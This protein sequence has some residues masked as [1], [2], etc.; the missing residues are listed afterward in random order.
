MKCDQMWM[1]SSGYGGI[2][3]SMGIYGE[4][5]NLKSKLPNLDPGMPGSFWG[6]DIYIYIYIYIYIFFF[7]K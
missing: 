3:F 4:I 7:F 5:C 6:G 2:D 1:D